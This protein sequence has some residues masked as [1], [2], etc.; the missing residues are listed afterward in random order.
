MALIPYHQLA[1]YLPCTVCFAHHC[2]RGSALDFAGFGGE[3]K[4]RRRSLPKKI[5]N[6]KKERRTES[7]KNLREISSE[8]KVK[9][10]SNMNQRR[11]AK[12]RLKQ[13]ERRQRMARG[14]SVSSPR[15]AGCKNSK[16]RKETL[17]R[18][19]MGPTK[20]QVEVPTLTSNHLFAHHPSTHPTHPHTHTH[21]HN[22]TNTPPQRLSE[23]IDNARRHLSEYISEFM[24]SFAGEVWCWH[25][26]RF[27]IDISIIAED[28]KSAIK[29]VGYTDLL[30]WAAY[31]NYE[32]LA[33]RCWKLC[34]C[35]VHAA[36][37]TACIFRC[38]AQDAMQGEHHRAAAKE[39]AD[40][41][42]GHALEILKLCAA[43]NMY[44]AS[45]MVEQ[46]VATG[47]HNVTLI[48]L[49]GKHD[50]GRFIAHDICQRVIWRRW[51]GLNTKDDG[52]AD[53]TKDTLV[54]S[55]H[56]FHHKATSV[57]SLETILWFCLLPVVVPFGLLKLCL[58]PS[59]TLAC[60]CPRRLRWFEFGA[61]RRTW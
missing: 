10:F 51:Y 42:E 45:E 20:R 19:K 21:Q 29:S 12:Y 6:L 26:S 8:N 31:H 7:I 22:H 57:S 23:E 2:L 46:P 35:P 14:S 17:V 43:E 24:S 47:Y 50:L 59:V 32:D 37:V 44:E 15:D 53:Y 30:L 25:S 49:A 61:V 28:S 56:R 5:I 60:V 34:A 1:H 4:Q 36:I 18:M 3:Q 13:R 39:L 52:G 9:R 58:P 16:L 40:K 27:S 38:H 54:H 41:Y 48:D 11:R 33:F 55:H